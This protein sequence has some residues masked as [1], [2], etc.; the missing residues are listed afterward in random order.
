MS[1]NNREQ[2]AE[3]E[4]DTAGSINSGKDRSLS[5]V[6]VSRRGFLR[7]AGVA[8]GVTA[9][10]CVGGGYFVSQ[11]TQDTQT[12]QVD[13]PSYI[14]GT[15]PPQKMR[16]LIPYATR[17]GSTI[18]VAAAVGETLGA[19]G[20]YVEVKP[21]TETLSIEGFQALV[22]GSAING[23]RWLPEAV[24]FALNNQQALQQIPTAIFCVHI[25][26]LGDDEKSKA[27]RLAY[28]DNVRVIHPVSEGF[29]AG[30][31]LNT[32]EQ[33]AFVRFIYRTIDI[34][35]EGDCRDWANIRAWAEAVFA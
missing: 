29:F 21:I 26:N 30:I 1:Q 33:N 11:V 4:P 22:I 17:T 10:T 12:T 24:D 6:R 27:N 16:I 2:M 5:K 32:D 14:F 9:L 34:G 31:G 13:T 18:G 8:L 19:L 25:M 35:P 15:D 7:C 28:L 3:T 23:G 20:N